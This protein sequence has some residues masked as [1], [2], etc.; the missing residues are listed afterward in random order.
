MVR[1]HDG[2]KATGFSLLEVL[3]AI[4]VLSVG[5]LALAALQGSLSRAS[6]DAKARARVA[7]MLTA[8]IDELR[9]GGYG[10]LAPEGAA[11][12]LT[13][14]EGAAGDGCDNDGSADDWLDCAREQ[15]N[16]G[17]LS[18]QQTVNTWYGD[19]TFATPAPAPANQNPRT[20]QFKRVGLVA[21]WTD[22]TGGVHSNQLV[23][24]IS[25]MSLTNFVVVPPDP[26]EN[27]TGGPI[28]RTIDPATSGVLPIAMGPEDQQ[29][30][31]GTGNPTPELI[32]QGKNQEIVGT[33]FSVLNYTPPQQFGD[34]SV[35]VTKR[36]DNEVIK[37]SCRYGAGGANLPE[38]YRTALWPAIWTGDAYAV[39][40]PDGNIAAPGQTKA[41]GPRSGVTQ[42]ELC[43]ECCRDH[44]DSGTGVEFDPERVGEE[45][46]Y[47]AAANGALSPANTNGGTYV[48][49]CRL[50]RIDGFWRT[51]ADLYQRQFGLLETKPDDNG[52]PA[53]SREPTDAAVAQYTTFVKDYLALYD[54]SQAVPPGA[55]PQA[56]FLSEFPTTPITL[57]VVSNTDYR[58]LHARGLYVDHLE[59]KAREKVSEAFADGDDDPC[60]SGDAEAD[61]I[62]QFLPFTTANLTEIAAWTAAPEGIINVNS[63]NLLATDPDDPSGGRTTGIANGTAQNTAQTRSS[64][65]GIAVYSPNVNLGGV[66]EADV[67][68]THQQSQQFDVGG[69]PGPT[70][71]VRALGGG[72][73][74]FVFF[75]LGIDNDVECFKPAGTDHRC[76]TSPGTILPQQGTVS[77]R[78]YNYE[79]TTSTQMSFTCQGNKAAS[80]IVAVPTFHNFTLASATFNGVNGTIAASVNEGML[81]ESTSVLFAAVAEG[82]LAIA[83]F[84]EEGSPQLA[85]IDSCK[86]SQGTFT[87]ITWNTPWR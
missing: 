55:T 76:G 84:T 16:L 17:S 39:H 71:D 30:M 61:C 62:L 29:M 2:R 32:G 19:A 65:S 60:P 41:S 10:S 33:R 12:P 56:E 70:F 87:Q 22:A 83:T 14:V 42:S 24:D 77:I 68:E 3:V 64:N 86:A 59:E 78:R 4:V 85:T 20:A 81:I 73:N 51:A 1:F 36:F 45:I 50:V 25:S 26:T 21:T 75:S 7:A 52:V 5:L 66:D 8:R 44:H 49:S 37:C 9:S 48:D 15:A 46:K 11:A 74:P 47:D 43:Q 82:G 57:P 34:S 31:N 54:G 79:D 27:P 18:V 67:D 40:I 53:K 13:S 80:G 69:P 58:F 23:S 63:A 38:I 28:V 72:G 6:A 35:V